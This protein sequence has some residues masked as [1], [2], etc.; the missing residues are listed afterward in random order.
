MILFV[1]MEPH[2]HRVL[3]ADAAEGGAGAD[4]DGAHAQADGGPGH[5][6]Q[7][8]PDRVQVFEL[9][10]HQG[11]ALGRGELDGLDAVFFRHVGQPAQQVEIG[12]N[13]AGNMGRNGV[14]FFVPLHNRAL[15]PVNLQP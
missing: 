13:P 3:H 1:E 4:L 15:F 11:D 8:L 2:P 5:H 7:F 6:A 10:S 12:D 14:G 9:E